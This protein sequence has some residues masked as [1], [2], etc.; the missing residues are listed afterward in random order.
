MLPHVFPYHLREKA[1]K[2]LAAELD[3][4]DNPETSSDEE[5]KEEEE[6]EEKKEEGPESGGGAKVIK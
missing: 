6:E 5:E 2:E 4:L 1:Q 3:K